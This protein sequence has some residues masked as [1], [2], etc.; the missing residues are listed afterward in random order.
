MTT[1]TARAA[2][3]VATVDTDTMAVSIS[4]DGVWS[5]DGKWDQAGR[6]IDSCAADLGDEAY[7]ALD[8]AIGDA[9]DE[10]EPWTYEGYWNVVLGPD[11]SAEDVVRE[12]GLKPDGLGEWLG[13]SEATAAQ[14]GGLDATNLP[15]EWTEHHARA[16]RQLRDAVSQ[17]GQDEQNERRGQ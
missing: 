17:A 1:I 14:A 8:E 3:Y 7:D 6:K 15:T 9:L 4:R 13:E 16:L 12:F 2:G 11:R 10:A 5:G